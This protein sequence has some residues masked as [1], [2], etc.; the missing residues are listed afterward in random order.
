[1]LEIEQFGSST[2]KIVS[3]KTSQSILNL[4]SDE[5]LEQFRLFGL[6]L[7]RGFGVTY[8]EMR[9]FSAKFSSKFVR[10]PFRPIVGSF[11]DFIQLVDNGTDAILPH[12]ENSASPFRP[13]IVWFCC[14]VPA[15][16]DGETLFWDGVKVWEQLSEAVKKLFISKRIKFRYH[17]PA[18]SWKLFFGPGT[19]IVDVQQILNNLE[20][21]NYQ[22][23]DNESI[24]FEYICS[25]VVKTK[26]GNQD[27]FANSLIFYYQEPK[28]SEKIN[29]NNIG[30]RGVIV[31]F[32]DGSQIP[33]TV[34]NEIKGVMNQLTGVISWQPGDI[35]MI[36]NS[37]F[38][39][40][41]RAFKDTRRKVFSHLSYL[42]S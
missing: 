21:V 23:Q 3:S 24:D 30:D 42:K 14:S 32:E 39:H 35:V 31:C 5:V 8:Q 20:N 41:R 37:R 7:F 18:D 40:G 25:V 10:D 29:D 16:Q 13:D 19:T 34:I 26:F 22:I 9:E 38:L 36:D 28:T 33:N 12:S 27:A 17:F 11:D 15:A 6:L 1:M 4:S 2:G